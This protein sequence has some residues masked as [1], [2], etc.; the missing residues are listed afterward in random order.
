M[1]SPFLR[2]WGA[3][4]GLGCLTCIGLL[5]ALLGDDI[6]DGVSAFALA[7]PVVVAAWGYLKSR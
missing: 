6:W 2:L 4:I 7:A 1:K 5:S 3:P